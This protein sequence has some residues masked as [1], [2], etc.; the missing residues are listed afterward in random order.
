M[1]IVY[2]TPRQSPAMRNIPII[3]LTARLLKQD[4]FL[5]S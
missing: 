1:L 2:H 4:H 5:K 3:L